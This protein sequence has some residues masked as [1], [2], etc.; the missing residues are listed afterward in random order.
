LASLEP[1]K[2]DTKDQQ[3]QKEPND[4]TATIA[5]ASAIG[6]NG[7]GTQQQQDQDDQQNGTHELSPFLDIFNI[8]EGTPPLWIMFK[9]ICIFI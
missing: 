2:Q 8:P 6:P 7:Q 9:R 3:K 1:V 4:P 5:P